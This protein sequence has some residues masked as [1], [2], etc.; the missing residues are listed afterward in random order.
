[1]AM[2]KAR[3]S[4]WSHGP[5]IGRETVTFRLW[6]PDRDEIGLRFE[7]GRKIAMQRR[8]DGFFEARTPT[9]VGTLYRFELGDGQLV[10]DP[11]SRFQPQDVH[12]PSELVDEDAYEWRDAGWGGRAWTDMVLYEIHLGT[13]TPDGSFASAIARLDHLAQLGVT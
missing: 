6:A 1:M 8:A 11:A 3:S 2:M 12:G 5:T 4:V 9:H 10:P 7:D 13:F